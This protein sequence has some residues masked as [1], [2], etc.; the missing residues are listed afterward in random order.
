MFS[1]FSG[2]RA[3]AVAKETPVDEAPSGR[4]PRLEAEQPAA[5]STPVRRYILGEKEV[6]E[7]SFNAAFPTKRTQSPYVQLDLWGKPLEGTAQQRPLDEL[8]DGDALLM[9]YTPHTSVDGELFTEGSLG[10]PYRTLRR[11]AGFTQPQREESDKGSGAESDKGSNTEGEPKLTEEQEKHEDV[12]ASEFVYSTSPV[13]MEIAET[14]SNLVA[15]RHHK[16]GEQSYSQLLFQQKSR[17]KRGNTVVDRWAPERMGAK[18]GL[19][20]NLE[21]SPDSKSTD[22]KLKHERVLVPHLR[23]LSCFGFPKLLRQLLRVDVGLLECDLVNSHPEHLL[24]MVPDQQL[25]N[26]RRFVNEREIVIEELCAWLSADRAQ[27]KKIV[28]GFRYGGDPKNLLKE[29]D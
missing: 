15:L 9:P 4:S 21:I 8:D 29:I 6:D 28:L 12:P 14:W 25:P 27:V 2:L 22:E 5:S 1:P 10:R 17:T 11:T 23:G 24:R 7:D 20:G 26:L 13:N 16:H 3:Q 18:L 19:T